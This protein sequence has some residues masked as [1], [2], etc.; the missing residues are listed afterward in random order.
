M[1]RSYWKGTLVVALAW[2]GFVWGQQPQGPALTPLPS[3]PRTAPSADKPLPPAERLPGDSTPKVAPPINGEPIVK[4]NEPGKPEQHCRLLKMWRTPEGATA[5]ELQDISTGEIITLVD[6]IAAE[7]TPTMM[8]APRGNGLASRVFHWGRDR[9][10]PAGSP[11]PPDAVSVPAE[12]VLVSP[13][14]ATPSD[15]EPTLV[16]APIVVQPT[17][18]EMKPAPVV[19][20]PA[21]VEMKPA[22]VVTKPMPVEMKPAPV[23]TKP[24]PV[25]MKPTPVVAQPLPERMAEPAATMPKP[26]MPVAKPQ[27]VVVKEP[28]AAPA[29]GAF[30]RGWFQADEAV[31]TPARQPAQ[32][33][34]VATP[35]TRPPTP[36]PVVKTQPNAAPAA[37]T[38]AKP[39]EMAKNTILNAGNSKGGPPPLDGSVSKPA[40]GDSG[41]AAKT[42]MGVADATASAGKPFRPGMIPPRPLNVPSA[43]AVVAKPPVKPTT[44]TPQPSDWRRSWGKP[45]ASQATVK[46]SDKLPPA[47][48][49]A[50]APAPRW[51]SDPPKPEAKPEP[52]P[53][54]TVR[55]DLPRAEPKVADPLTAPERYARNPVDVKPVEPVKPPEPKP[56]AAVASKPAVEAK[57]E[58]PKTLVTPKVV[59]VPAAP[60]MA[61]IEPTESAGVA[62]TQGQVPL[63]AKSVLAAYGDKPT[64]V[65]YLPVPM[66]TLPYQTVPPQRLAAAQAAADAPGVDARDGNAFSNTPGKPSGPTRE[67]QMASNAFS[68]GSSRGAQPYRPG[69]GYPVPPAQMMAMMP[70][71]QPG[72][73]PPVSQAGYYPNQRPAYPVPVMQGYYPQAP[74]GMGYPQAMPAYP[75]PGPQ[76]SAPGVHSVAQML[77]TL[78]DALYPSHREWAAEALA[79][80]D[81]RSNPQVVDALMLAAK[82]DPA[83]TVRAGAVRALARMNTNNS[84]V[85][86]TLQGLRADPDPRV[87]KDVEQALGGPNA[88]VVQPVGG[89]MPK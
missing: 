47:K 16:P 26:M 10:P 89:V 33:P 17:T 38:P 1:V 55:I 84:A 35:A 8:P 46:A 79:I 36:V 75:A 74:A 80:S 50:Q 53:I 2:S 3:T 28:E 40:Q 71:M 7:S 27:P 5:R 83:A 15:Q 37:R 6:E 66:V 68:S 60:K 73:G 67:E 41:C 4:I 51:P 57:P 48:E 76:A 24:A 45:E 81:W 52:K 9:N 23:V 42:S 69:P 39:T 58:A 88:S 44:E 32:M 78:K 43:T 63:G 25:E 62:T 31:K 86:A 56:V 59:A 19:T 72:Y 61:P 18:P 29:K 77:L 82:E 30:W 65:V 22:P 85:V 14:P 11:L 34:V 12:P 13:L 70:P 21:P 20:K 64:G 49:V 54:Q 87:R